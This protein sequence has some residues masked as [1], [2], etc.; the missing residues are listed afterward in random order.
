MSSPC[1]GRILTIGEVSSID[2]TID[3]V[4]G[5]SYRL[6]EFMLGV[7]GDHSSQEPENKLASIEGRS[8]NAEVAKLLA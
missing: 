8:N 3:A 4:K 7:I 2:S 5:R 6:D 1:D